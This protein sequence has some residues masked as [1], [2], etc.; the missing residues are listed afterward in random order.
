M[1]LATLLACVPHLYTDDTAGDG[2]DGTWQA[3]VNSWYTGQPPSGLEGEGCDAGEVVPDF[4][5]LDQHGDEVSLWQFY[6]LVT[7]IDISALWCKPCRELAATV[8]TTADEFRDEGMVYLTVLPQDM[9]SSPP[10]QAEL[11]QWGDYFGIT[12]PILSDDQDWYKCVVPAE[13]AFPAVIVT[14]RAMQS[15]GPISA[16]D[17]AIVAAVEAR[18]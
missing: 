7:V 9:G 17:A 12:E 5:L 16:T 13:D 14:D 18:L 2:G 10:D 4:R 6:G 15:S 1:F 11:N 8:Q 3:P